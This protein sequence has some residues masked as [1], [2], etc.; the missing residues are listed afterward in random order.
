MLMLG[1][2]LAD[3]VRRGYGRAFGDIQRNPCHQP[4]QYVTV[5]RSWLTVDRFEQVLWEAG[6]TQPA[7]AAKLHVR[8]VKMDPAKVDENLEL[9]NQTVLPDISKRRQG[10]WACICDEASVR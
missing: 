2:P 3:R 6:S 1:A 10:S 9:F 8:R 5:V 7:P 4:G